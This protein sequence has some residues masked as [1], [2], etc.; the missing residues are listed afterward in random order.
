MTMAT[1]EARR[2]LCLVA[3]LQLQATK[4]EAELLHN[5]YPD[6]KIWQ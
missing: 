3:S 6:A 4:M 5:N 2:L 1:G